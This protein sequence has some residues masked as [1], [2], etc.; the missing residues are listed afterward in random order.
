MPARMPAE[1]MTGRW[2]GGRVARRVGAMVVGMGVALAL[3][4]CGGADP[5]EVRP[6]AVETSFGE[7]GLGAG[8]FSYPRCLDVA[9]I[10]G[11]PN[12][13]ICD[14]TARIQRFDARTG[15]VLGVVRTPEWQ[16]GKPTGITMGP[17]PTDPD[18]LMIWVADTHYHRVLG[19][20]V[21]TDA[22]ADRLRE[23][24]PTEPVF[25]FGAYGDQPGQF[26]YPTDVA[27]LTDDAGRVTRVYVSEYG[28][29]DRITVFEPVAGADGSVAFEP[30]FVIGAFG[31]PGDE[32]ADGPVLFNRP[33]TMVI[34][35]EHDELVVTDACNHR[36]RRLTLEGKAIASYGTP[37]EGAGEFNYPY[38]MALLG[39]GSA[40]VC[41]FGGSRLQRIDLATGATLGL[42][43]GPGYAEGTLA[44]P[45]AVAVIGSDAYVLDSGRNRV[46]AFHSPAPGVE[47]ARGE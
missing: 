9:L 33:Q 35:R 26:I 10:D 47:V 7:V 3:P 27:L 16:L 19:Y 32:Q 44:N 30:A 4:S 40:L 5:G 15:E 21:P 25:E 28:G 17:H 1:R 12:L 23:A 41:E 42:L 22:D 39:D 34:D 36:V 45:W 37:G 8:Q 2:S 43:G 38:G 13:F 14:K 24:A 20:D 18:R 6:I 46:L 11:V 31:A 29:N